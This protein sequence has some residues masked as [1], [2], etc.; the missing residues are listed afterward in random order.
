MKAPHPDISVG[1]IVGGRRESPWRRTAMSISHDCN[2]YF[3]DRVCGS[4]WASAWHWPI[5]AAAMKLCGSAALRQDEGG[6]PDCPWRTRSSLAAKEEIAGAINDIFRRVGL[7]V[8]DVDGTRMVI[9]VGLKE[10]GAA[11]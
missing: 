9:G 7:P 10:Q 11:V 1:D 8:I 2:S 6:L 4:C 3:P 5:Y